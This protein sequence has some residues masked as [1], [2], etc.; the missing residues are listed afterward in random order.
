MASNATLADAPANPRPLPMNG[1]ATEIFQSHR[2][3]LFRVAYRMLESHAEAEDLLQDAYLRWHESATEDIQSP[4]AFLV[5]L[6]RRLCVDR[7]R[8]MKQ[9]GRY[10]VGPWLSEPIV[11]D[12]FPSPEI[13]L[14]LAGEV[15]L[16]FVAVLERLGPEERVAFLLHDVFDYD[17][18]E[19]AQMLGK[20]EP[21]CRQMIHR[22]RTRV[23]ESKPRFSVTAESRERLLKKFHAAIGTGDRKAVMALLAEDVEYAA[24]VGGKACALHGPFVTD[25]KR[26]L[27]ISDTFA[28]RTNSSTFRCAISLPDCMPVTDASARSS[29]E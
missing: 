3:R 8:E 27:G 16:A 12:Q 21:T 15:S 2:L 17:Y 29:C 23:R 1:T 14:E 24:N 13:Q 20:A 6:T 18:P 4:I 25:S 26:I 22:A 5:T 11:E 28:I 9:E 10:C 19:V 7:L